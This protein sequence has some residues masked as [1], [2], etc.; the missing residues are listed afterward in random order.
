MRE[1]EGEQPSEL[2]FRRAVD[3]AVGT[4]GAV[5]YESN[6]DGLGAML[7]TRYPLGVIRERLQGIAWLS[8]R[9][10][11]REEEEWKFSLVRVEPRTVTKEVNQGEAS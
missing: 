11:A 4:L 3:R 9:S 8:M 2:A 7:R 5:S 10:V 6:T 1:W